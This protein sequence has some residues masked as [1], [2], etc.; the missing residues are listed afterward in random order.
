MADT[1][2]ALARRLAEQAE[3]VCHHYLPNGRRAGRYWLVGDVDNTPGRSLY[4][5]LIGTGTG[6]GAAGKWTDAAT[7]EHGDLLDLIASTR[8]LSTL[9]DTLDEARRFLSLPQPERSEQIRRGP[10]SAGSPEAARRLFAMSKP[11]AGTLAEDYLRSRGISHSR[12]ISLRFHPHCFYRADADDPLDI[13]T[14]WPALI[15]AVTDLD[16]NITGVH[17]TWLD[18]SG[19][20]K[21]P[22]ATPRRA[23]GH[24]LG[25]GV[26]FGTVFDA[27]VAGEGIETMLSLAQIMPT[28]P[29]I[30]A[31]SANHLAALTF[32][33]TLRRLY[34]A[35]DNDPAGGRA[36]H[37]LTE[38]AQVAG[39]EALT[40]TPRL[41]D[42]NDDLRKHGS[43]ALAA[44]VRAQL[45]PEDVPRFWIP[46]TDHRDTARTRRSGFGP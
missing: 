17:R 45:V 13:P 21:A 18:P 26:R 8:R 10:V 36:T 38:R 12:K 30:A 33:P 28:L 43:N 20:A 11:I 37:T 1:A 9:A 23:M 22:I 34:I 41:D 24:L 27:M 3:T 29:G 39:I 46:D 7:G 42:F 40:L 6:R 15:A 35:R 14:A 19:R 44:E 25:N 31:S 16:G 5:R 32:P 4:V 2:S